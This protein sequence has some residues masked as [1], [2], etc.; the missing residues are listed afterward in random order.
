MKLRIIAPIRDNAT[1]L[2][3][4]TY[5]W[6]LLMIEMHKRSGETQMRLHN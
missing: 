4:K 1:G 5:Q 2:D 3:K 6:G